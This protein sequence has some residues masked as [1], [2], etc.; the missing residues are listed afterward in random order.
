MKKAEHVFHPVTIA[1]SRVVIAS[2][3]LALICGYKKRFWIPN[4]SEF[5]KLW[6]VIIFGFC[7]P[8][9]LQPFLISDYGSG[10]I[11]MMLAF[12]P[13]FTLFISYLIL[14]GSIN[15]FQIF[16]I[17]GGLL[18][19]ALLFIDRLN[20]EIITIGGIL[21]AL[22]VPLSYTISN[23]FIK[24]HFKDI[25]PLPFTM[26]CSVFASLVLLPLNFYYFEIKNPGS[27][28]EAIISLLILGVL[29]SAIALYWFYNL[30]MIE[31]PLI[32]SITS[33]IIPI[34]ALTWG[35]LDGEML[36]AYQLMGIAGILIM[37]RVISIKP[38]LEIVAE[39][40]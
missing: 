34:V 32:A 15:K 12:L 30:V 21:L 7:F 39:P 11:G 8:F 1:T 18:F 2:I 37:I 4:L 35:W 23:V 17:I 3:T 27:L 22:T 19:S 24:K 38:K 13:L 10:F 25:D 28:N 31:G 20:M 6:F 9:F 33:Y 26:I 29:M 40:Y 5:K 36:T 16:G 14:D